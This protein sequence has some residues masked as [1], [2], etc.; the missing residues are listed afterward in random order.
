MPRVSLPE[1]PRCWSWLERRAGRAAAIEII[2]D[3]NL[4]AD[5]ILD[6]D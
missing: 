6:V 4:D 2:L 3:E 1:M 5:D